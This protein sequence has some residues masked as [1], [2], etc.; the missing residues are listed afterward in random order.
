MRTTWARMSGVTE[1]HGSGPK[2]GVSEL[3]RK[4]AERHG[5]IKIWLPPERP[6]AGWKCG[7]QHVWRVHQ[8]SMALFGRPDMTWVFVC[9]HQIEID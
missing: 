7:T 2:A 8:D 5:P 3:A 4:H 1:S 6:D 9:E